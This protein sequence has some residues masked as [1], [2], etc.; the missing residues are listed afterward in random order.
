VRNLK[1]VFNWLPLHGAVVRGLRRGV[2][3]CLMGL[4]LTALQ[5]HSAAYKSRSSDASDKPASA[6][7]IPGGSLEAHEKA[8]GHLLER[9]V[10]KTA[11]QLRQRLQS[12]NRI[13]AASSF[14][15]KKSAETGV[16]ACVAANQKK[17]AGWLKGDEDRLVITHKSGV[18][19]GI[20][21]SRGAS[22]ARDA[23]GVRLVLV[24]DSRF[25]GG[26]KILTGYPE[27]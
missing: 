10:G 20:S 21:M 2:Y 24:R 4:F 18:M 8:G 27:L 22:K 17:I 7:G 25:T 11:E 26:W 23:Q 16:K 13:S 3:F 5:A 15:D 14:L 19:L 12:D 1:D 6:D 9:H